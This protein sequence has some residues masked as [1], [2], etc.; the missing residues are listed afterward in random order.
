MST[1][2]VPPL[3]IDP[4]TGIREIT[5][6][7]AGMTSGIRVFTNGRNAIGRYASWDAVRVAVTAR[8][9]WYRS[10]DVN[11]SLHNDIVCRGCGHHGHF[12]YILDYQ[13][14]THPATAEDVVAALNGPARHVQ[15]GDRVRLEVNPLPELV[16]GVVRRIYRHVGIVETADVELCSGDIFPQSL[17]FL[18]AVA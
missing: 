8:G 4:A 12:D 1:K 15:P 10:G 9:H 6:S 14:C 13:P 18:I 16:T 17:E 2:T 11:D 7:P 5:T 3:V